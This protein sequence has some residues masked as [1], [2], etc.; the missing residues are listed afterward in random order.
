[1]IWMML[2]LMLKLD[3]NIRYYI[4]FILFILFVIIFYLFWFIV[5]TLMSCTLLATCLL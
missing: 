4:L 2:L 5:C 1:M 3:G